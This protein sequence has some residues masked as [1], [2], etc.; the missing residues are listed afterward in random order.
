MLKPWP[1][2][3]WSRLLLHEPDLFQAVVLAVG[4]H[5]YHK[6]TRERGRH[7]APSEEVIASFVQ[8]AICDFFAPQSARRA[9]Q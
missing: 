3:A 1:L 7:S 2:D 5:T 9:S 4:H 6:L 8:I